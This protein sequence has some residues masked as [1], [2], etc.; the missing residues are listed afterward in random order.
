M[1]GYQTEGLTIVV[2]PT[3]SLAD[4]QILA[5]KQIIKSKTV[6]QEVFSYKS[7]VQVPPIINAIQNRT[8]R[9]LFISPEAL[10][11]NQAFESVLKVANKQHYIK[12]YCN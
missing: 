4:D 3:V 11:N 12:K 1:L 10:M 2:V 8:A 6:D 9:L 5:A 7:G